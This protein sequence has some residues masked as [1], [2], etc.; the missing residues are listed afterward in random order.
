MHE[1]VNL[2]I[3]DVEAAARRLEHLV[4]HTP[5]VSSAWLSAST[6]A[7]VWLKLEVVQTTGSFKLRG[8]LNALARLHESG[9]PP[10]DVVTASAGNHGLA[11]GWAA[12]HFG[13]RSRVHLPISAPAV[14]REALMRLGVVLVDAPT[15][16]AAE[17]QAHEDAA[18]TGA[19]FISPY[20]DADVMAG[21]AT[22]ALEMLS[23][24]PAL[25]TIVAP[26]GGGG[27]LAGT[28]V[29]A[30]AHRREASSAPVRVIGAEAEASPVFTA[31]LAAGR[32]VTVD[33]QSTVADG[34][35]GNMDPNSRTFT[36]VRDL[37]DRVALIAE[38]S[39]HVAMRGL[40]IHER[41]IAEGAAATA[42]GALLQGGLDLAG[43][44][45]GVILTGR[46]VDASVVRAI[47]ASSSPA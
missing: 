42:V 39:I 30:R 7:D 44:K 17:R 28:A 16:D 35:A 2:A 40:F 12:G 5:L 3:A 26:I 31:S 43:R 24:Q 11:I 41:L 18:K 36:V 27:L 1:P 19:V 13:V 23:D 8:A 32:I 25:D 21:A 14:K 4:W 6:G 33:V 15:Y 34:L 9:D 20:D 10:R 46:N 47:L 37:A 38:S 45:V 22:T 29:V